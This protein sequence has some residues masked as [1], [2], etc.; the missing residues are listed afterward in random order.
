[1]KKKRFSEEQIIKALKRNEAGESPSDLCRELGIHQTTFF[2]WKRKFSGLE[3]S[4][5]KRLRSLEDENRRLK[6]MVA[7]LSLDNKML[8]SQQPK[9]VGP[10]AKKEAAMMLQSEFNISERRACRVVGLA[11]S[12]KRHEAQENTLNKELSEKLNSL[13]DKKKRFGAP[14]LHQLLLRDGYKINHKR[15]ERLYK[16]EGLSLRTKGKRKKYKSIARAPLSEATHANQYWAM[17]FVSDQL[18]SGQRFRGLTIVDIFTRENPV[19]E[20]GRSMPAVRVVEV[21]ERLKFE[22]GKPEAIVLDNGPEMVSLALDQWAYENNVKFHFIAPGKPTQ[23]AFIESFNGTFR[24]EYLNMHWF[25][26]LD[27]ARRKIEIWRKEYNEENPHSALG[28]L[29]PKEFAEK[30]QVMLTE[31]QETRIHLKNASEAGKSSLKPENRDNFR[32]F[33]PT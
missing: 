26:D 29:T 18:V 25:N 13:A 4:E 19:I 14:R 7:D 2:G 3:V 11:R 33:F 31:S 8:K 32:L 6:Q 23:N 20:I 5:A 1:M 12:T 30:T 10:Q 27:D 9:V 28:Y 24:D 22:R 16:Q 15:T 17:D 21:L